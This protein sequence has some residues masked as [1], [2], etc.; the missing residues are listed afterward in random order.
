MS[1]QREGLLSREDVSR[2]DGLPVMRVERMI[3][4]LVETNQ[5]LSLVGDVLSDARRAGLIASDAKLAHYLEP[6]ARRNQRSSGT[7]LRECL[8]EV[9]GVSTGQ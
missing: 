3:A 8:Y 2:V 6:L 4:D 9:A 1:A 7:D 5:D